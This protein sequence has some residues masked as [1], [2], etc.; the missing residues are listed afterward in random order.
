MFYRMT[1]LHWDEDRY[2]DVLSL[3][4]SMRS[5]VEAISGLL[6]AELARTGLGEG[7]IIAAYRSEA[8]YQAASAEVASILEGLTRLLTSTPHGHQGTVVLSYGH[9]PTTT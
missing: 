5:R 8:D 1:R 3:A 2:E 4:E 7:M 6:F 9:A